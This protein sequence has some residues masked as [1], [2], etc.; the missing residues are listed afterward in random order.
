MFF[1]R[2]KL[3]LR[4]SSQVD[5][6]ALSQAKVKLKL[7]QAKFLFKDEKIFDLTIFKSVTSIS[8]KENC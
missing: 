2:I 5:S 6:D 1:S 8:H 7:L 3:T 4:I